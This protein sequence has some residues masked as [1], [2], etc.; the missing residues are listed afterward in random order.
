MSDSYPSKNEGRG[1]LLSDP[2]PPAVGTE[3]P[4][5]SEMLP[6]TQTA[7][8]RFASRRARLQMCRGVAIGLAA[9]MVGMLVV[10]LVDHLFRMSTPVRTALTLIVDVAAI[11]AAWF[12]GIRHSRERDWTAIA[13]GMEAA[14]PPLRERLLSAVEL[15]DPRVANGSVEFRTTLQSGVAAELSSVDIRRMLPLSLVRRSIQAAVGIVIAVGLLSAVPSLQLPRRLARA[16]V[17]MAPIER[18]SVTKVAIVSPSPPTCDV[19]EG[20]L[21]AVTVSVGRLGNGDVELQWRDDNGREGHLRMG[22]RDGQSPPVSVGMARS[23]RGV[24]LGED[25]GVVDELQNVAGAER[26]S[27]AANVQVDSTSVHYRVLAGD[28]ETLWHTL[29]PMPRPRVVEFEKRYQFP[30]YAKLPDEVLVEEHGDLEAIVGTSAEVT[31]TFD[32]PVRAAEIVF[33]GASSDLRIPMQEIDNDL[34]RFRFRFSITTPGSYRVNAI[35]LRGELDNPFLPRNVIDPITDRSPVA[36][37]SSEVPARQICSPASVIELGGRVEDDLPMDRCIFQYIRDDGPVRERSLS[38]D[39]SRDVHDVAF[40]WDMV[41]L[42]GRGNPSETMP[43]GTRLKA[44]LIALDRAG[45][46]GESEWI[47]VFI[48]GSRFDPDRHAR[49]F[50]LHAFTAEINQWWND[51]DEWGERASASVEAIAEEVENG[52]PAPNGQTI[53]E[54]ERLTTRWREIAGDFDAVALRSAIEMRRGNEEDQQSDTPVTMDKLMSQSSDPVA[55]DRLSLIDRAVVHSLTELDDAFARW[56]DLGALNDSLDARERVALIREVAEKLRQVDAVTKRTRELPSQTLAIELSTAMLQDMDSISGAVGMLADEESTIPI[57]RLPGQSELLMERLQQ[58]DSLVT[59]VQD[60]LSDET[61]NHL[62]N[63]RN[64]FGESANRIEEAAEKMRLDRN[65]EVEENFRESIGRLKEDMSRHHLGS[66][67]HGNTY[68]RITGS[69]RDL[70]KED[71]QAR[72]QIRLLIRAGLDWKNAIEKKERAVEKEDSSEIDAAMTIEAMRQ[73][74]FTDR[75]ESLVRRYD[76]AEAHEQ[77][78]ADSQSKIAGDFRLVRRVI[79]HVAKDGWETEPENDFGPLFERIDRAAMMLESGGQSIRL[80][81]QLQDMIDRERYGT[82]DADLRV[83][84]GNRLEH[85]QV[86]GETP[87]Q[88]LQDL[89]HGVRVF[90]ELRATR[91]NED[92]SQARDRISQRRYSGDPVVSAAAP[93]QRMVD[94]YGSAMPMIET[95]MAEARVELRAMLPSTSELAKAAAEEARRE[96]EN[97]RL[98]ELQ[99]KVDRVA[100]DLV[101]RANNADLADAD[102]RELARDADAAL[103]KIQSEMESVASPLRQTPESETA[104]DVREP[105]ERLAETLERTAEHFDAADAGEDLAETRQMLREPISQESMPDAIDDAR[106]RA[107]SADELAQATPEELL[108][109]LEEQ[110]KRDPP[111]QEDLA[112]ISDKTVA[113]VER[114]VRAA[115]EREDQL[116]RELERA[117]PEFLEQKRTLRDQLRSIADQARSVD[118]QW[119]ATAET[120]SFRLRDQESLDQIRE[121]RTRLRD[122][123]SGA[124]ET[125]QDNALMQDIRQA[126]QRLKETLADASADAGELQQQAEQSSNEEVHRNEN[127]QQQSAKAAEAAQRRAQ[128]EWVKALGR[129]KEEWRRRRDEASR[130]MQQNQN[131]KRGAENQLRQAEKQLAANPEQQWAKQ[132]VADSRARVAEADRAVNAAQRTRDA[133]VEGEKRADRISEAAKKESVEEFDAE[134]PAA[135]LLART[136][137]IARR[138]MERLTSGLENVEKQTQPDQEPSPSATASKSLAQQQ[139][140]TREAVTQAAD[141][142]QRAAR[143]EARLGNTDEAESLR[144]AAEQLAEIAEAPMRDAEQSLKRAAEKGETAG[145]STSDSPEGAER[146]ESSPARSQLGEASARLAEQAE[147]IARI[148]GAMASDGNDGE[149][150]NAAV[151]EDFVDEPVDA[152]ERE[153][154]LAETD[155][156]EKLARTLDELDR[157]IN[158]RPPDGSSQMARGDDDTQSGNQEAGEGE[159]AG[160]GSPDQAAQASGSESQSGSA[161]GSQA[162]QSAGQASSTLGRASE[163]AARRLAAS[164]QQRLSQIAA[165]GQPASS[166]EGAMGESSDGMSDAGSPEEGM[167]DISGQPGQR[168]GDSMEMPGGGYLTLDGQSRADGRWGDLRE[169]KSNDVIQDRKTQIPLSYRPAIEAYFQAIAAEASRRNPRPAGTGDMEGSTSTEEGGP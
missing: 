94:V 78:R 167:G 74:E 103:K 76:R 22:A 18:A 11:A 150:S 19:A 145:A 105:L 46:R 88:Q 90:E 135:E 132:N 45:H 79:E 4:T 38:I 66:L 21:V 139:E 95:S 43:A 63:V 114:A 160:S 61:V 161:S 81:R 96:P 164:R 3:P 153:G 93:V 40:E 100:E 60:E 31:V 144:E 67:V 44:R 28:A 104:P 53:R 73:R 32:Q 6:P 77:V 26:E 141:D 149:R 50:E 107:A 5:R 166:S 75:R 128:N 15:E 156:S 138:E 133:A 121:M 49:L 62:R 7:I 42:A 8:E 120:A 83:R 82:S 116:Q 123:I 64:F 115:S 162:E 91:W 92:Y 47:H 142:L 159:Q 80:Q 119:L 68:N 146:S 163:A 129:Q 98:D 87:L 20:D 137:E 65:P 124:D 147:S 165:A 97:P 10:V 25:G 30:S 101:D 108:R 54:L 131:Q 33:G 155:R 72:S 122:A 9:L 23:A 48:G 52:L 136:S 16:F 1:M 14:T 106:E 13:R 158:R 148:A 37:W 99:E 89:H 140:Q 113:D 130:R 169:R 127:E 134:N 57:E 29:T 36:T 27:F 125:Q 59:G 2:P 84:Q 151:N 110:L 154:T 58:L 143:H 34:T 111:M 112:E 70:G 41:D 71:Q 117:D 152:P 35:S 118:D 56:Q 17:P 85:Y 51:L 69:V 126:T 86:L 168:S 39:P 157:E 55:A 24:D 109:R 12:G 102:Q